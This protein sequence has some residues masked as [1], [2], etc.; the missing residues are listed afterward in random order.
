MI[1][2]LAKSA[3]SVQDALDRKGLECIVRMLEES[4]RTAHEAAETLG[5]DVSQI[6]KSLIF[7][8]KLT[9][10][11]VLILASGSNRVNEKIIESYLGEEILKADA[12]FTREITGFAIGGIPP[13]GHLQ[14]IDLIFIDEDLLKLESLWAAAGTPNAVFNLHGK[15]LC[16]LTEGRV[17]T[18]K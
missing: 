17:V 6:V 7:K 3:Q 16:T 2:K 8:T 15:D 1:E 13:I 4:T 14:K 18:L 9:Q 11:P 5:C 10:R 12:D